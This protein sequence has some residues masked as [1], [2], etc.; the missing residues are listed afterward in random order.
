MMNHSY[1]HWCILLLISKEKGYY[2]SYV[3]GEDY[4]CIVYIYLFL[5]QSI[6]TP[7]VWASFPS[8]HLSLIFIDQFESICLSYMAWVFCSS[9]VPLGPKCLRTEWSIK[10]TNRKTA[11]VFTKFTIFNFNSNKPMQHVH[12]NN[13]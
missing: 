6:Y 12:V 5:N 2:E 4:E 11:N 13:Y 1:S 10:Q 3:V 9:L 8:S 7:G